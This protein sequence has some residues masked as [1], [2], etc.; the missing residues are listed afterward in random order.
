MKIVILDGYTL[1][2]GDLSWEGFRKLGD[3]TIYDRT[4]SYEVFE[5]CKNAQIII[6]NKTIIDKELINNLHDLKYIGIL[7]TGY[8]VVDVQAAKQK[9]IIVTNIPAYGTASVAQM[10]FALIFDITNH[11]SSH[12]TA[13]KQGTWS[14]SK[15]FCF[16]NKPIIELAGKTIGII[17]F[18]SIGRKVADIAEVLDMKVIAYSRT[19]TDESNR[20]SFKWVSLDEIFQESDILS[21]NCPLNNETKGIVNRI[22]ISKMKK[23]SILINA[24]RGQLIVEKHLAEALNS[25]KIA[26]AGVDVL[27]EEPPS[28]DNPLLKAKNCIIT[29]HI[30]WASKEAR[31]RLMSIAVSNL[32]AFID[33]S[34]VNII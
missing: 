21:L 27:C 13:V 5:R 4:D 20:K 8:N 11:V 1:N 14:K 15:D 30:A 16:W 26:A 19:I 18:G 23:S 7:A 9:K 2:P 12:N 31:T 33:G 3:V 24:S 25:G 28:K 32:K 22:T 6:T 17:G 10:I 29:P 34:P